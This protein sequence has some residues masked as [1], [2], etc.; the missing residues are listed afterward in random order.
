MK[1]AGLT[2]V[3]LLV[4]LSVIAF[5]AALLFPVFHTSREQAKAATC[6]ARLWQLA[7]ALHAYD[8]D[9]QSFPY[10]FGGLR[11]GPPPGGYPGSLL[12]D[13]AGWWWFNFIGPVYGKTARDKDVL[14]CPSKR[15]EDATLQRD[16]LCGNYGVNRAVCKSL[17]S[18]P[19]RN[20]FEGTP[21]SLGAIRHPAMTLLVMDSGYSLI[22][23][24]H[25]TEAP[26]ITLGSSIQDAA[27]VPGLEINTQKPI[28]PAQM[29]DACDEGRHP[30]KTVNIAFADSHVER[31]KAGELLVEKT[32]EGQWN[33]SPLWS[34]E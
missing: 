13:P 14:R 22:C 21:L 34:P 24:W 11:Q 2:L 26:P 7:L 9:N 1:P 29:R 5:L 18:D 12:I 19:P 8:G 23:W 28:W 17:G 20:E 16:I 27:Y 15:L 32:D 25:A 3:E 31:R 10:G 4:V 33:Y 6:G 30:N